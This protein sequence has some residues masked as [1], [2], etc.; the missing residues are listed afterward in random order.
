[1]A[2]CGLDCSRC[3]N[4]TGGSVAIHARA[5]AKTMGDNFQTYADRLKDFNPAM[6]EYPAFRS[7]LDSLASP[8]CDGCRS[9]NRTCLPSC[10]VAECVQKQHIEFCFECDKFP[11]CEK[12]GLTGALLERWEKNNKLMKSIG[13]D[14]YITMSAEKPRY[15]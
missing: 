5:I 6:N 4:C 7:L 15:P 12:T 1:M 8:K 9:D 3:L 14:K 11:D 10:K 2:P 13:I